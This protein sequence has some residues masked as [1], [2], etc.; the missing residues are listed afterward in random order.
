MTSVCFLSKQLHLKPLF[1]KDVFATLSS[2]KNLISLKLVANKVSSLEQ[3]LSL[4]MECS[5]VSLAFL[6]PALHKH[7]LYQD[8]RKNVKFISETSTG[9]LGPFQWVVF[10]CYSEA[11]LNQS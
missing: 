2:V 10:C 1:K 8:C 4:N 7:L 9:D 5:G 3:I 6:K 11:Q